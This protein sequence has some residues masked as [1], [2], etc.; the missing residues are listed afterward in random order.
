[1]SQ[2]VTGEAVVLELRTAGVPSRVLAALLDAAVQTVLMLLGIFLVGVT[3]QWLSAAATGALLIGVVLLVLLAYPVVLETLLR[4]RTLGKMAL[5]LRVVRDDGGGIRFRHAITRGLIGL[6]VEKPGFTLGFAG[7]VTALLNERG[8]RLGDL[9]AGTVVV[10][11]RVVSHRA[12]L[13]AMPPP[14]AGW[15][16]TLDLSALPDDLAESARSYL[17]RWSSLTPQAQAELGGR[18]ASAVAAVVTP[19]P[20]AGVPPWA[21]LSAVLAERRRRAGYGAVAAPEGPATLAGYQAPPTAAAPPPPPAPAAPP[22]AGPSSSG[23]APP[24]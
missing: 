15:A 8:K 6:F 12:D 16:T 11:E 4:G 24:G 9:F 18:L 17:G 23:F 21:Y 22:D 5:G 13:I 7:L 19:E 1:V 10:Q 2:L 14:L 3:A 20:P